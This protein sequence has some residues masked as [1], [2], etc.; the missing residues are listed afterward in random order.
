MQQVLEEI[1]RI[2]EL[3]FL[4]NFTN[5][6]GGDPPEEALRFTSA[7]HWMSIRG[8]SFGDHGRELAI[9]V[10]TPFDQ[11]MTA[12]YGFT[13]GDAIEVG[14]VV[15]SLWDASVNSLLDHA[16]EFADGVGAHLD[17]RQRLPREVREKVVTAAD[18]ENAARY[19]FV[20][21]F[22]SNVAQATTFT[23]D[24]L[25]EAQPSLERDRAAAGLRELSVEIGSIEPASYSGLF[26]P[27]PLVEQP[28][29]Q[30]GDRY[31]LPVPGMLSRDIFTVFDARLMRAPRLPQE[32]SQDA[33]PT[34]GRTN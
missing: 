20:D 28:F 23:L 15:E 9:A 1:S 10:F 21:V 13:I 24:E 6:R 12:A 18:R 26:D 16:R 30:H 11:W 4:V 19:A 3:V 33:R 14:D 8:D 31:M 25:C 17:D 2:L 5:R 29:L 22:R 27:S 32:P 7:M 34:G